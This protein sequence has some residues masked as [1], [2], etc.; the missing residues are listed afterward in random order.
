MASRPINAL[1]ASAVAVLPLPAMMLLD[2]L[3]RGCG[4]GLCGFIPGLLLLGGLAV[5]TLIFLIRSVRREETPVVMRLLP[6][7]LWTLAML[8]LFL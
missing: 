8:P 6:L 3:N 7:G 4:D 2:R 1:I 5:A